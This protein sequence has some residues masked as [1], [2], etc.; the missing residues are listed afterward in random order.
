MITILLLISIIHLAQ[1]HHIVFEEIG[2]MTRAISN[3]HIVL[4]VDIQG[5]K[6]KAD[7]YIDQIQDFKKATQEQHFHWTMEHYATKYTKD[8]WASFNEARLQ[9]ILMI[10]REEDDVK[11]FWTDLNV[12]IP[13]LPNLQQT[14]ANATYHQAPVNF[15]IQV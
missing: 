9:H 15:Q 7:S 8:I 10:E 12:T 1:N 11:E 3:L 5:L 14:S 4:P 2:E 13:H 6:E